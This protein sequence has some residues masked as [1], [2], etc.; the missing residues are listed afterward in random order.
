MNCCSET[1]K[2]GTRLRDWAERSEREE[3]GRATWQP[4]RGTAGLVRGVPER[5]VAGADTRGRQ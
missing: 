5:Y 2:L 3:D 1:T 4:S